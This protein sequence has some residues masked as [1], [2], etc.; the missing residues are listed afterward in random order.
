M[1]TVAS[2]KFIITTIF[3]LEELDL[4]GFSIGP[5][6]TV[7]IMELSVCVARVMST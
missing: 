3:E 1:S 2:N 5:H 7:I 4:R 6:N